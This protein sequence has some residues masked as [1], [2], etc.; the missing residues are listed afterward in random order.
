MKGCGLDLSGSGLG[1][2]TCSILQPFLD[3]WKDREGLVRCIVAGW[4]TYRKLTDVHSQ[5]KQ[6]EQ[7]K[8]LP[9]HASDS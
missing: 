7:L 2:V 5:T 9:L 6:Q 4:S 8:L 1:Q 3:K